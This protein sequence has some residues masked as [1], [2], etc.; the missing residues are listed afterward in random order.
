[1]NKDCMPCR[2]EESRSVLSKLPDSFPLAMAYVRMQP[3]DGMYPPE[4]ALKQ[5]T[6]YPDLDLPF[7]GRT[8]GGKNA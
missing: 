2:S 7:C 1:M 5:G 8:I 4:M 3:F 6:L